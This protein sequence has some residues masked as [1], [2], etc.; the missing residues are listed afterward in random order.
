MLR[1]AAIAD[2][3]KGLG[4]RTDQFDNCVAALQSA[5][6]LLERGRTLPYFL[7]EEDVVVPILTGEASFALPERF[8]REV[9][10]V[11]LHTLDDEDRVLYLEKM[12]H[13]VAVLRFQHVDAD[14]GRPIAYSLLKATV[15][16]W[17]TTDRDR[18][19]IWT[20]YRGGESLAT[21]IEN[22]WL[23]EEYGA[24]EVLIA[25]AGMIVAEDLF[26]TEAYGKFQRRFL[27]AYAGMLGD[28]IQRQ[29]AN[30]PLYMGGR[31]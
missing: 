28:T 11:G 9:D 3:Q 30:K 2:I 13:Q 19:L 21:N 25:R 7:Q 6:R 24:P 10:D 26:N 1:D 18:T 5:Q 14:P 8:L 4:F 16:L 23:D 27:E 22:A 15:A 31:L 12:D 29:E 20:Y 17:P